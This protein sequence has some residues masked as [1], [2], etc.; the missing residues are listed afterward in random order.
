[1]E[2]DVLNNSAACLSGYSV[3]ARDEDICRREH[4]TFFLSIAGVLAAVL[5]A[6]AE[7]E[8]SAREI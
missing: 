2:C 7:N 5:N 6:H 1:M 8:L 4:K 3:E